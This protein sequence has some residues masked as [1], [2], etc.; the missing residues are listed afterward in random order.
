MTKKN[1]VQLCSEVYAHL[2]LRFKNTLYHLSFSYG[3][4]IELLL[5]SGRSRG[6]FVMSVVRITHLISKHLH[7]SCGERLLSGSSTLITFAST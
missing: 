5:F 6:H 4:I 2:T 3:F 7:I 1:V